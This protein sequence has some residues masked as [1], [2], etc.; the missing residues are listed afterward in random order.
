IF[1]TQSAFPVTDSQ[2]PIQA[3]APH[4]TPMPYTQLK[5]LPS[6]AELIRLLA[7][8]NKKPGSEL[9]CESVR[10]ALS[11]FYRAL[12]GRQHVG[13]REE[14]TGTSLIYAISLHQEFCFA[15]GHS[16]NHRRSSPAELDH[17]G[18]PVPAHIG[19]EAG[20]HPGQ[21]ASPPTGK[22]YYSINPT[23]VFGIEGEPG[24]PGGNPR[25]HQ[26]N[27]QTPS[28]KVAGEPRTNI[29]LTGRSLCLHQC[30]RQSPGSFE[31][32]RRGGRRI[33]RQ[34]ENRKG[35]SVDLRIGTLNVGTMT[36][37]GREL[38]DM[39]ERR[40]VDILCVQETRWKGSKAR[41]IGGG[42]KLFYYG[43]DRKRNGV[44]VILK[45]EFVRNVLEVKRVSD[46]VISLKLEIEGVMLNVVS[47]YAPQ[48]GCKLEE[49]ERFWKDKETWWWNE[50]VQ[51][52]IQRK[53][54]AKKKWDIERTEESRQDYKDSQRR[55]KRE[56]TLL[57]LR[58]KI[59]VCLVKGVF[60]KDLIK[61]DHDS[62]GIK[63]HRGQLRLGTCCI[64][65]IVEVSLSPALFGQDA[66]IH[67]GEFASPSQKSVYRTQ[68]S[69]AV[70]HPSSFKARGCLA[71]EV[72]QSQSIYL[73]PV[74]CQKTSPTNFLDITKPDP[75]DQFAMIT[76]NLILLSLPAST[77]G[78]PIGHAVLPP[79]HYG[80]CFGKEKSCM[81]ERKKERKKEGREEGNKEGRMEGT[82]K[83]SMEGRGSEEV[84]GRGPKC[85]QHLFPENSY[86]TVSKRK[87]KEGKTSSSHEG[88]KSTPA[89]AQ[90]ET[91]QE[92]RS[93]HCLLCRTGRKVEKGSGGSCSG[94]SSDYPLVCPVCPGHLGGPNQ[95]RF[96]TTGSVFIAHGADFH[97]PLPFS[98]AL[99]KEL[100]HD[101]VGP[102]AV[103]LQRLGGIAQISTVNHVPQDLEVIMYVTKVS[104]GILNV[105]SKS[106]SCNREKL[107]HYY[108]LEGYGNHPKETN[109]YLEDGIHN[110]HSYSVT[111]QSKASRGA[112]ICHEMSS[113]KVNP[114]EI[115]IDKQWQ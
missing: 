102:L 3:D 5:T 87:C 28:R 95:P 56:Q 69:Q 27:M 100:L 61:R 75:I 52:I 111:E 70:P 9:M 72:E 78:S 14:Q 67:P 89:L 85:L 22:L 82:G 74:A 7:A 29:L 37:K 65:Q 11:V 83:E 91:C 62:G 40:K 31:L 47:G 81:K 30:E 96:P 103:E 93:H 105:L 32:R 2:N 38:A 54:L 104:A 10:Q 19:Q 94:T 59:G 35:R 68:C 39:M 92:L 114:Q 99:V 86:Q 18:L 26:E 90:N 12:L 106:R 53:R 57:T 50:E 36:G 112:C 84:M 43:V 109:A 4:P 33:R 34:K 113:P 15:L 110:A 41:S 20:V 49:K 1:S 45:E 79:W 88:R 23:R 13:K 44:G 8:F 98:I 76:P 48:V 55:V 64:Q 6:G 25:K 101:A 97:T 63:D 24:V 46:R 80:D 107:Y 115:S 42:Y 71:F 108:Y 16:R 58:G 51:D 60:C 17:G 66:R 21:V 73:R 77:P